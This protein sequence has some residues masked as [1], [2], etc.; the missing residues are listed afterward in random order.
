M[1]SPV[2]V[3]GR[4]NLATELGRALDRP[5]VAIGN[6]D[7][8]HRGHQALIATARK[9]AEPNG[10]DVVALTFDPHPARLLAPAL[11]PPLIVS[12]ERRAE[13]LG[14]AGANVVVIEPFTREFAAIDAVSFAGD[15]LAGDL[16]SAHVVVGYDFSFGKGRRGDTAMLEAL[17]ARFGFG[18]SIVRR[19]AIHGLTCSSTKVREFAL[20]GR[21]EG[22]EVL[23]GRPFELTGV[24]ARGAGRGRQIGF[25]TA[26]LR[27][28]AELLPKP[29]IYAARAVVDGDRAGDVR[30]V[31]CSVSIGTNPT[32]V[33]DG[34]LIV[35]AHLLDFEGDLY[36]RRM[37]IELVQRLRDEHRY[38]TVDALITQIRA[39][40]AM[41]R[42]LVV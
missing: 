32:F 24:V 25:P 1:P 16:R 15:V 22:A 19:I 20:E 11:A 17:G 12:L 36:G 39:D 30:P 41:T 21:V 28:D 31:A 37:R 9:L 6:F 38:E 29:G 2:I 8:V 33:N 5:S 26:N 14:Q 42:A 7:G 35:E 40:V 10:G 34:A 13:L 23:L 4:A 27:P 3:H 18:V